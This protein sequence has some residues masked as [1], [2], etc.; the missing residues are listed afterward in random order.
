MSYS[1]K[2]DGKRIY[3]SRAGV[4]TVL[5]TEGTELTLKLDQQQDCKDGC[6]TEPR[7][8][9]RRTVRQH[10]KEMAWANEGEYTFIVKPPYPPEP[11]SELSEVR[12]ARILTE[13][14]R[15]TCSDIWPD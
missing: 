4:F 14:F 6:C 13:Y 10:P 7:E 8:N 12:I 1:Y 5:S 3:F 15:E 11:W 9:I 2:H